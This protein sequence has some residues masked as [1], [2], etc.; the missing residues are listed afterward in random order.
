M[1]SVYIAQGNQVQKLRFTGTAY[2]RSV[3]AILLISGQDSVTQPISISF[4]GTTTGE[5]DI[6]ELVALV[7]QNDVGVT[8]GSNAT[9]TIPRFGGD[10]GSYHIIC[11]DKGISVQLLS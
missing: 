1:K 10:W 6:S 8:G 7:S 2:A 9:I 4:T 3:A 5:M 11:L